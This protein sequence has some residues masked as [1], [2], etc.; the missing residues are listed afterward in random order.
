MT[1][2]SRLSV[3]AAV[4]KD[5]AGL[6]RKV[7]WDVHP[8]ETL[9]YWLVSFRRNQA[10]LPYKLKCFLSQNGHREDQSRN[11]D[12]AR[13]ILAPFPARFRWRWGLSKRIR[14]TTHV[15]S[16]PTGSRG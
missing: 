2:A 13:E 6:R 10:P 12:T 8:A 5:Y 1:W 14:I 3:T 15:T 11:V 4:A 16:I 9:V 7:S